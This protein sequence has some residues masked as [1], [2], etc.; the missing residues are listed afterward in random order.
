MIADLKGRYPSLTVALLRVKHIQNKRSDTLLDAE[1]RK[2]EERAAAP[3]SKG[4]RMSSQHTNNS[5][6]SSERATLSATNRVDS[7]GQAHARSL[8]VVESVFMAELKH[9]FLTAVHDA[10]KLKGELKTRLS[11]RF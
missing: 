1:K 11:D 2:L 7:E 5:S 3:G 4:I 10:D 9:G 8:H 6:S